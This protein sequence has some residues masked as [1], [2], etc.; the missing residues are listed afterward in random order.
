MDIQAGKA[1][2]QGP[3]NILSSMYKSQPVTITVEGAN[4][5][6]RNL[7]I[8]GQCS[9]R[10]HPYMQDIM[11]NLYSE[12][13][14]VEA[15][16]KELLKKTIKYSAAN[17]GRSVLESYVPNIIKRMT[18]LNYDYE[19]EINELSANLAIMS[20]ISL[21]VMGG[22]LKKAEMLSARLGDVMSYLYAA[23]AVT[24]Y[25]KVHSTK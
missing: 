6:T 3:N 18:G 4:I 1:I 9:I 19:P 23:L 15:E 22:K 12:E 20:D 14:N 25:R 8:F 11:T 7:M 24:R 17:A 21:L 16:F 2:Q 5:L 10:S 13:A